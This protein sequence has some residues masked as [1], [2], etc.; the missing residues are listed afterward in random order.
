MTE[1]GP[2]S[3]GAHCNGHNVHAQPALQCCTQQ[4]T[5]QQARRCYARCLS[6]RRSK[7]CLARPCNSCGMPF[8]ITMARENLHSALVHHH[9]RGKRLQGFQVSAR[10]PITVCASKLRHS[11]AHQGA[12][13][14]GV[15][16]QSQT[17]LWRN[18]PSQRHITVLANQG[19]ARPLKRSKAKLDGD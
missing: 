13:G 12:P 9:C 15:R 18:A 7:P 16:F 6:C 4:H 11:K 1:D 2:S 19:A 3:Q 5:C 10:V 14:S 8:I 17:R